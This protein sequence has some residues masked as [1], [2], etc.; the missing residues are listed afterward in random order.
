MMILKNTRVSAIVGSIIQQ[1]QFVPPLLTRIC[2]GIVFAQ[3]GWGKLNHLDKAIEYF[4]NL[5]IP[6]ASIQA[7]MVAGLE[8]VGGLFLIVG[9]LTRFW[10]FM[11]AGVM[12]VALATALVPGLESLSEVFG[13]AETSYLILFLWLFIFGAGAISIDHYGCARYQ[14]M[15]NKNPNGATPKV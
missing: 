13:L 9:L 8:F 12:G 15:L 5:G 10:S 4:Q 7:P 1:M 3:A 14:K 11:L 2:L 6:F